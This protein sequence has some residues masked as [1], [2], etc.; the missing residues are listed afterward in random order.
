[1]TVP[2][3]KERDKGEEKLLNEIMA[4]SL[5]SLLKRTKIYT[6]RK[7][8]KFQIGNVQRDPQTHYSKNTESQKQGENLESNKRKKTPH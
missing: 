2:E 7:L 1:M 4:E 3:R 6:S 5:Q 8:N